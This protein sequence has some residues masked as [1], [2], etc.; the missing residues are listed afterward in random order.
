MFESSVAFQA[1][2]GVAGFPAYDVDLVSSEMP[3]GAS[4]LA[5]CLLELD[6]PLWK[7]WGADLRED[8]AALDDGTHRYVRRDEAWRRLLPALRAGREFAFRRA[9]TPRLTHAWPGLYPPVGKTILFVRDPRDALL[10]LWHRARAVG[11]VGD[12]VDF[13]TF[14][15]QPWFHYPLSR[16]DFLRVWLRV[17]RSALAQREHLVLRYEDYRADARATLER[18][19][20]FLGI[21]A[22]DRAIDAAVAASDFRVARAAEQ[23]LIDAGTVSHVLVRAGKAAEWRDAFDAAMHAAVGPEFADV[24]AWLGYAPDASG[25]PARPA[26]D[27]DAADLERLLTAAQA[28]ALAPDAAATLRGWCAGAVRDVLFLRA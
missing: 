18:A 17:W 11:L 23:A 9:P 20:A 27:V 2:P 13:V 12:D 22:A 1:Y 4:W 10:S 25:A 3:S 26:R 28:Q 15:A 14:V 21:A 7:P 19:L 16:A 24:Y 5:N 6:V 8:F